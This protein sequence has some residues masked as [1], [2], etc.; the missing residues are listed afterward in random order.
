MAH[1]PGVAHGDHTI[2]VQSRGLGAA[3]DKR[4]A[5]V[6]FELLPPFYRRPWIALSGTALILAL[7]SA[8]G[9]LVGRRRAHA[10]QRRLSRTAL[11]KQALISRQMSEMVLVVDP[12]G[13]VSGSNPAAERTLGR[14]QMAVRSIGQTLGRPAALVPNIGGSIPNDIFAGLLGLS[15]VWVPH[16]YSGCAQHAPNEHM[17]T[18]IAREGLQIMT[19]LFWDIGGVKAS[20]LK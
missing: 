19:G 6:A 4:T 8:I 18:S 5:R 16:S 10:A 7:L 15:T 12:D 3:R 9:L 20:R 2:D 1:I 13:I 14:S 11:R 17:L